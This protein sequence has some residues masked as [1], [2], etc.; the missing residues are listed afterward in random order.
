MCRFTVGEEHTTGAI[1]ESHELLD[2]GFY[3]IREA[4]AQLE[5]AEVTQWFLAELKRR[6]C[7]GTRNGIKK[8]AFFFYRDENP[9]IFY[10]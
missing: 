1:K 9:T 10:E 2:L 4:L 5:M 8:H 7:T 3:N 6:H